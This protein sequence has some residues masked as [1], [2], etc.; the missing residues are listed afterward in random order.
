MV[1]LNTEILPPK[2]TTYHKEATLSIPLSITKSIRIIHS[3][4]YTS[5]TTRNTVVEV[6][7]YPKRLAWWAKLATWRQNARTCSYLVAKARTLVAKARTLVAKA[8]TLVAKCS[9]L[10]VLGDQSSHLGGQALIRPFSLI[11]NSLGL[12]ESSTIEKAK[13]SGHGGHK[14]EE[15]S[16]CGKDCYAQWLVDGLCQLKAK[17]VVDFPTSNFLNA[18]NLRNFS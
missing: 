4:V 7:P 6:G 12:N 1:L 17:T 8:R 11:T 10:L 3:N 15:S 13:K 2:S 5:P 9:Y 14:I 16:K 18:G